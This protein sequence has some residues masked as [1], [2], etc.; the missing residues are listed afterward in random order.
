MPAGSDG[1]AARC[2]A[3]GLVMMES[4][5]ID[6]GLRFVPTHSV[7]KPCEN[8]HVANIWHAY[9]GEIADRSES[10]PSS[11]QEKNMFAAAKF[12]VASGLSA[13]LIA[14]ALAA[15]AIAQEPIKIGLV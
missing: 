12:H 6:V 5:E 15:P 3:A 9:C 11:S 7:A 8:W 1:S 10:A 14:T 13:A 4:L 2:A